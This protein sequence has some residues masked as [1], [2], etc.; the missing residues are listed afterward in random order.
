MFEKHMYKSIKRKILNSHTKK[1]FL[2][3]EKIINGLRKLNKM[4]SIR[5]SICSSGLY[6]EYT[7]LQILNALNSF[8]C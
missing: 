5:I 8:V 3:G 6:E 7:Y 4:I 2:V 1:Y